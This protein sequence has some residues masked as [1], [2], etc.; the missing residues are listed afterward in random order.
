MTH[1]AHSDGVVENARER[2]GVSR[3]EAVLVALL[4]AFFLF[5]PFPYYDQEGA[6][7]QL[8]NPNEVMRVYSVRAAAE[9][10]HLYINDVVDEWPTRKTD[11]S[12]RPRHDEEPDTYPK[13]LLYPSKSPGMIPL[14]APA[15]WAFAHVSD[16]VGHETTR[17]DLVNVCRGSMQLL[18]LMSSMVFYL[19]LR[20]TMR[21]KFVAQGVYWVMTLGTM[22]YAYAMIYA[23]HQIATSALLVLFIVLAWRPPD[24]WFER[25]PR[26]GKHLM[27]AGAGLCGGF[28]VAAEYSAVLPAVLIGLYGVVRGTE[29]MNRP[30]EGSSR[31]MQFLRSR[32][33][34]VSVIVGVLPAAFYTM[35]YHKLAF[36]GILK[37]PYNFMLNPTFRARMEQSA[38]GFKS[39]SL[40]VLGEIYFGTSNGLL[41]FMPFL[42]LAVCGVVIGLWKRKHRAEVGLGVAIIVVM[43]A[44]L[45]SVAFDWVG[46][47][48]VGPRYLS[49]VLPAMGLLAAFGLDELDEHY[50]I[51]SRAFLGGLGALSILCVMPLSMV[52]PHVPGWLK[53]PVAEGSLAIVAHAIVPLNRLGLSEEIFAL[54]VYGALA[55]V[56]VWLLSAAKHPTQ[57]LVQVIAS[58][59]IL[60]GGLFL[61]VSSAEVSDARSAKFIKYLDKFKAPETKAKR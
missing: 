14:A 21:S 24:R 16:W 53:H 10:G 8:D 12:G 40:E 52:F 1:G 9:F 4:T 34:L 56:C 31:V 35:I 28:A 60:S 39:P 6:R 36:G 27:Y 23:S 13:Q 3:L 51:A 29:A 54:C 5:V 49:N 43:S 26:V 18:L 15:W 61:I 50:S 22:G 19:F 44:Y 37:T 41:T 42:A 30:V 32:R 57:R 47:W 17:R 46:G 58:V 7:G 55:T 20:H 2:A 11:M 59:A 45:S 38:G 25:L 48:S 33:H